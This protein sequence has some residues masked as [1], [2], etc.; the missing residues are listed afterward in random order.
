[1]KFIELNLHALDA[2]LANLAEA[3][4]AARSR[5]AR[6]HVCNAVANII[7][8]AGTHGGH[9]QLAAMDAAT[10]AGFAPEYYADTIRVYWQPAAKAKA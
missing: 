2:V 5:D 6:Q 10:R 7:A 3:V 8:G 4:A 9:D 1:M